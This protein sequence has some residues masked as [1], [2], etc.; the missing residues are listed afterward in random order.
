MEDYKIKKLPF[1][2][3]FGL[4]LMIINKTHLAPRLY[5]GY[6]VYVNGNYYAYYGK[7]NHECNED[8]VSTTNPCDFVASRKGLGCHY[9]WVAARCPKTCSNV[10]ECPALLERWYVSATLGATRDTG[11]EP[12][13][14]VSVMSS[15]NID[16]LGPM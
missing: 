12:S 2:G 8:V 5:N 4:D 16:T 13:Q 9:E 14:I 11:D 10:V 7:E 3:T 6:P 1:L 15:V